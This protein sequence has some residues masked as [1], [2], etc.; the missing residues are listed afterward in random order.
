MNQEQKN[1]KTLANIRRIWRALRRELGENDLLIND[2]NEQAKQILKN[3][4]YSE[5][6]ND[7]L[8]VQTVFSD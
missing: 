3:S 8:I 4:G 7:E 1:E 2:F 5:P 6:I